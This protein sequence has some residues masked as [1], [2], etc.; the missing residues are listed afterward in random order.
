MP[1]NIT[2]KDYI[3]ILEYYNVPIPNNNKNIKEK[4]ETILANK[5]CGCIKKVGASIEN[6]PKSIGICTKTI[7]NKRNMKRG[8]FTCK[9]NNKPRVKFTKT[10]KNI[11]FTRK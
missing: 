11:L 9:K 6:E 2:K 5:L 8:K 7:F 3:K 10:K 1:Y 4:A